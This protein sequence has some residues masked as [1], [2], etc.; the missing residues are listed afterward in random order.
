MIFNLCISYD[1]IY[2]EQF[3]NVYDFKMYFDL[4]YVIVFKRYFNLIVKRLYF[5][6]FQMFLIKC[7]VVCSFFINVDDFFVMFI[8]FFKDKFNF[9]IYI[10]LILFIYL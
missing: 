3:I 1:V 10:Y 4:L 9:F 2:L 7:Y 6:W 5:C 8:V